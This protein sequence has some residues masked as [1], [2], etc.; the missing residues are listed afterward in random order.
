MISKKYKAIFI[1]IEKTG[2]TSIENK[3]GLFDTLSRGVQDHTK[4]RYY[5]H[6]SSLAYKPRNFRFV[7]YHLKRRKLQKA[8]FYFKNVFFPELTHKQYQNYYKFTFV[9]NTW[10]RLYSYYFNVMKD[11]VMKMSYGIDDSCSFEYFLK[12]IIDADSFSAMAYIKDSTGNVP[13]DYIGS[14]ETLQDDFNLVCTRINIKN[15]ELPKLLQHSIKR[16]PYTKFYTDTTRTL[17]YKLYKEE[18]D[19]FQFKFGG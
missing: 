8:L 12:N 18:I 10:D 17:V 2:G 4:I 16:E 5:E 7:F 6:I 14:F 11:D 1:H 3:L 15:A 19:Y 13:L 9:R